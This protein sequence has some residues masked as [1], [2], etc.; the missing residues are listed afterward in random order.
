MSESPATSMGGMSAADSTPLWSLLAELSDGENSGSWAA[1]LTEAQRLGQVDPATARVLRQLHTRLED[2]SR[3]EKLLRVLYDTSTDLIGIRDVEA[4]LKAIVRRTRSLIGS[5]IAYLSLN[6]YER[7]ESYIRVTDGATTAQFR[8]IRIPLGGGVL[9][10]VATGSAPSQS[11]DY[12]SDTTKTHFP[13]S[14]AAVIA[15]GVKAIMG[16]PLWA[17]GRVIGAL[18]VADR[19]AHEFSSDDISLMES[20]GAHAAVALENARL[21]TEMSATVRQL[22]AAQEENL[23]HTSALETLAALDRQL[24]ETLTASDVVTNLRELV[25]DALGA[26]TWILDPAGDPL[27]GGPSAH[28]A[29]S[30]DFAAA[31]R[32]SRGGREPVAFLLAGFEYTLM[33]AVAGDEHLCTVLVRTTGEGTQLAVLE[34]AGL[35]LTAALLFER[36]LTEAQYRLQRE[37]IDELLAPRAEITEASLER[38]RRFGIDSQSVLTVRIVDVDVDHRTRAL[39]LMRMDA[40]RTPGVIAIHGGSVC[41]VAP[42]EADTLPGTDRADPGRRIVS[43]LASEG[44]TANVGSSDPV[45]SLTKLPEAFAEAQA[46]LRALAALERTGEAANRAAL[47]T[48]GM[49]LASTDETF[50]ARLLDAQLGG[51]MEYDRRRGTQLLDTAWVYLDADRSSSATAARLLIHPNTLRQRLDR[52]DSILGPQWRRGTRALDTQVALQIWRLRNRGN[53]QPK[54]G[55]PPSIYT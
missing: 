21:F 8:N 16:V 28:G 45:E 2:G 15:E 44:I 30:V 31:V 24:M 10:A 12:P 1:R 40:A 11:R 22:A 35:V 34:R 13:D 42:A 25:R 33:A 37:L 17:E 51:L 9:G 36:S 53:A 52:I 19:R 4:I 23:R 39:A 27:G 46:V 43:I 29:K 18:M 55:A 49:L 41:V 50:A 47:G 48:A 3:R 5:D 20:I 26:E 6:D 32:Q 54:A 14:D 7:N 38:A